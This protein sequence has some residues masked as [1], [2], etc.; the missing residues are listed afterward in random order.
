MALDFVDLRAWTVSKQAVDIQTK[1]LLVLVLN[2]EACLQ[3]V[4]NTVN[5]K[6][7]PILTKMMHGYKLRVYTIPRVIF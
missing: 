2:L 3:H 6:F 1:S 5:L 4:Q 7:F